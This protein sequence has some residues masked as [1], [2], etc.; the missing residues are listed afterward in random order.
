MIKNWKN[1]GV[2]RLRR[3][4][5]IKEIVQQIC[6]HCNNFYVW[7]DV[8]Y[9]IVSCLPKIKHLFL[10]GGTIERRNLVMILQRCKELVKLDVRTEKSTLVYANAM[11]AV[12]IGIKTFHL[13]G[14]L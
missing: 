12:C 10:K 4:H 7:D 14:I 3:A 11:Q 5:Y 1:L 8:A 13:I 2:L 6:V 9:T